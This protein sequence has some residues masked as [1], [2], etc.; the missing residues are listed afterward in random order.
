[1]LSHKL[2]RRGFTA[3]ALAGA[4]QAADAAPAHVIDV[5]TH[6]YDT[7]RPQGVPWPPANQPVLYKPT[8]PARYRE[9]IRPHR[10]DGVVAIEASPWL[11]DNLWLLTLA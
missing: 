4:V 10:V 1:M 5:A 8:F 11:E 2:T 7:S 6:F 9:A 3:T